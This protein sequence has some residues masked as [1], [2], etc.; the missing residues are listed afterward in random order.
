MTSITIGQLARRVGIKPSA[1][2]YYEA[3]GILRS[4]FR[5]ANG[6]RLYGADAVILLDFIRS[7]REL[8]LSLDE[9]RRIIETSRSGLPCSLTRKMIKQHLFEVEG[10]LSR[11]RLLRDRLK[12]MLRQ[13]SPAKTANAICPLIECGD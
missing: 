6:Y 5:S 2:R 11:L 3:K 7:S 12:R 10:E 1:I 8:G 13:P 4:A 9:I